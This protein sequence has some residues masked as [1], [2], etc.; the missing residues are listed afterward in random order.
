MLKL[1]AG[2]LPATCLA[3]KMNFAQIADEVPNQKYALN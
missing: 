3:V 1:L 2:L